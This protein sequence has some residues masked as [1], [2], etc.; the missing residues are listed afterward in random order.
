MISRPFLGSH[1]TK[2]Y[3]PRSPPSD[4]GTHLSR[5]KTSLSKDVCRYPMEVI[6]VDNASSDGTQ[7]M[8]ERSFPSVRLIQNGENFGFAKANNIG[9]SLSIGRYLCLIN[10]D[11]KVLS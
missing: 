11:V 5:A 7:E 3:P 8:V 6:V 2:R 4:I 10:S 1:R 9:V